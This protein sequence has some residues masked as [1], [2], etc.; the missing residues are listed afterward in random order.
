MQNA[1]YTTIRM[2]IC[3][4]LKND[5]S[6][7]GY[8]AG[9]RLREQELLE[10]YHISRSP[11]REA[12]HQL[13][14][15]GLI[16]E[17]P[18]RGALVRKLSAEE[19]VELFEARVMIETYAMQHFSPELL[20]RKKQEPE[21]LLQVSE[22]AFADRDLALF[23]AIDKKIHS[24]IVSTCGNALINELYE[25]IS[26]RSS[27]FRSYALST[28]GR[29]FSTVEEHRAAVE[30]FLRDDM[31]NACREN[32]LHLERAEAAVLEKISRED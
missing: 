10:R 24:A 29:W 32:R 25:K 26:A 17:I 16:T 31:E 21:A 30:A 18:N 2:Q 19:I 22:Q 8:P 5:I 7:G 1:E 20:P 15:E 4:V 23:T 28:A 13:A 27:M 11:I 9:Y 14:A 12:L 3:N 6:T